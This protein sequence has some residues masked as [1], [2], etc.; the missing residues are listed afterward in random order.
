MYRVGTSNGVAPRP[1]WWKLYASVTSALILVA[2]VEMKV[3]AGAER[4]AMQIVAALILF[5]AMALWVRANKV[6]L[7]LEGRRPADWRRAAIET[8][9]LAWPLSDADKRNRRVRPAAGSRSE[10]LVRRSAHRGVRALD[11]KKTSDE[12]GVVTF[13]R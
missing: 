10:D 9:S 11:L 5:G 2:L 7:A 13:R 6:E 3:P 4:T 1:S 8:T 12:S